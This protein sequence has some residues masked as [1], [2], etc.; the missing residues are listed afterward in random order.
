MNRT[1]IITDRAVYERLIKAIDV[2]YT[3][4]IARSVRLFDSEPTVVD[5]LNDGRS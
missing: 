1:A 3:A 5:W 4:L 2:A